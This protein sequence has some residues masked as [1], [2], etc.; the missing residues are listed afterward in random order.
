MPPV[1]HVDKCKSCGS[2]AQICPGDVFCG[3]RAKEIPVVAYP[4]E[5]AHCNACVEECPEGAISIRV[6]LPMM[7]L[8]RPEWDKPL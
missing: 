7:L 3:S 4:E 5:C 6:P 8:Y 2:C 1:I